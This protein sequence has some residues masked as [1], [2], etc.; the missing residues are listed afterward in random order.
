MARSLRKKAAI[1]QP[2]EVKV[3]AQTI[4]ALPADKQLVADLSR[5]GVVYE[6]N[7]AAGALDLKRIVVRTG[8][9]EQAIAS[10]LE[11]TFSKAVLKGLPS[12]GFRIGAAA[13]LRKLPP[14]NQ[15]PRPD[16][17][18]IIKCGPEQCGG[19]NCCTCQSKSECDFMLW[20]LDCYMTICNSDHS[21]CACALTASG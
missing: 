13:D 9:R 19:T 21:Y 18:P 16:T 20:F 7:P 6:F 17:S 10:L 14:T 5:S 8:A 1:R 4:A 12:K 15:N 3:N 2:F 11:K